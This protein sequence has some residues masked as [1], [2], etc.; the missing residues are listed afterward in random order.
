MG[1]C[2]GARARPAP[3]LCSVWTPSSNF[4][5]P[6]SSSPG[7]T[8]SVHRRKTTNDNSTTRYRPQL[9]QSHAVKYTMFRPRVFIAASRALRLSTATS[10]SASTPLLTSLRHLT[11]APRL[12][13]TTMPA[14]LPAISPT[15]TPIM[16]DFSLSGKTILV[17]G[18]ARGLGLT[19]AEALIDA[20]ATVH[21]LDRLPS[22]SPE[23]API[24]ERASKLG[25]SLTYHQV[26]VTDVPALNAVVAS[27][28]PVHGLIA[29]AGIQQ[30]TPALDYTPEDCNR[31]LSVNVTG[32]FMTA[33]AVARAMI[34]AGTPGSIALIASMSG[35][36]AN[37]GL[38]CPAYNASKAAVVQLGRN[39]ASEW[40]AHGIR[41]N[42]ISPGYIVTQMV[43]E[44]FKTH[45][46]RREKW[47]GENM[48]GRLS[49]PREY[50]GAAVFLMSDA[51][52][53]MT[54]SNM[55]IDGGHSA[56]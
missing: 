26:D 51:S 4:S 15:P 19:Q 48:L 49:T 37:R 16:P 36:I 46:E 24:A 32:V 33:Q 5:P 45:P 44:L 20:G 25:T 39:L 22:P 28:G 42:T 52:S 9:S 11:P 54:G 21:C 7:I 1:L 8:T 18:G 3:L 34:A 29:A 30:E 27:I 23:F 38:I 10:P 43:E 41:V 31:M 47:S 35:T 14:S 40:G 17:S 6:P 12:F 2:G 53:F 13:S 56:W 55:I 50:R